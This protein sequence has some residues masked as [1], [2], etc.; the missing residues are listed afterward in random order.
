VGGRERDDCVSRIDLVRDSPR[1][2]GDGSA[3]L[4]KVALITAE[5][6]FCL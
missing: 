5:A 4:L 2:D 6:P 1:A 3:L